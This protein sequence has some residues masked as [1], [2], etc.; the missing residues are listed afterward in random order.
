LD[1]NPYIPK[2]AR[3]TE[4]IAESDDGSLKTFSVLLQDETERE[5]FSYLPGQFAELSIAG[6]GEAPF[7]MASSPT[8]GDVLRFTIQK[9]GKVTTAFH[10][11]MADR[12]IGIRGPYG[13]PF[14]LEILR[15]HSLVLI[16]GGFGITTLRSLLFY[17]M[18]R[19]NRHEY[20]DLSLIY[21]A[22]NPGLLLYS[23]ELAKLADGGDVN[24][25]LTIDRKAEGWEGHTGYVP[26]I[27]Q[28]VGPSSKRAV[29]LV[30]GPSAMIDKTI[31]VL[32]DQGFGDDRIFCSM[33]RRMTCGIGLCG[34]CNIGPLYVCTDGPVFSVAELENVQQG[35]NNGEC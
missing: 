17:V 5:S 23:E 7:G 3:I 6:V 30:C 16:G 33:E 22:R 26:E 15:G 32:R 28:R 4:I 31:P 27:V 20:N 21:G 11:L 24:I 1:K 10:R 13:K 34:R 9:A 8:E 25:Q 18:H 35:N 29:A 12:V 14:P 19:N 2:L